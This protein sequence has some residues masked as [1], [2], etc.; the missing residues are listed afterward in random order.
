[1]SSIINGGVLSLL[2]HGKSITPR[3]AASYV[4]FIYAYN[5]VQC[6]MEDIHRR[7]SAIHNVIAGGMMGSIGVHKGWM[8]IPFIDSHFFIRHPTLSPRVVA[9][10]VYGS[11]GGAFALLAGKQF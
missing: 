1:M 11:L 4:S 6:P 7:R 5:I 9:F 2:Q 8:G 10:A 3:V